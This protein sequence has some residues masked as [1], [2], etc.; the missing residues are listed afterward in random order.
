MTACGECGAPNGHRIYPIGVMEGDAYYA[1]R[2]CEA[3]MRSEYLLAPHPA[4]MH[5]HRWERAIVLALAGAVMAA[6][7]IDT[8]HRIFT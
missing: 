8:L 6:V 1:C 5:Q 7:V 2:T 4:L 3:E